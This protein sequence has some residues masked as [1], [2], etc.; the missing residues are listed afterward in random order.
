[1]NATIS[2]HLACAKRHKTP[3]VHSVRTENRALKKAA[4]YKSDT[5]SYTKPRVFKRGGKRDRQGKVTHNLSEKQVKDIYTAINKSVAIGLPLNRMINVHWERAGISTRGAI[6]ATGQLLKY[7][8]DW[9][10]RRGLPFAYVWIRE[11]DDGDGSKGD[12]V[13]I[14]AHIPR[15]MT[16]R[17]G[18]SWI[19][20][21]TSGRYRQGVLLTCRI[22]GIA[23]AAGA[24]PEHYAV[25]L[26]VVAGYVLK[27][28]CEADMRA[29][30]LWRWNGGGR[31]TG[32]RC[33][34]SKNLSRAVQTGQVAY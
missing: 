18:R 12:H 1:M 24:T 27:G 31:V 23:N 15:G 30:G 16:L 26:A 20:R 19:N 32:Q 22:G 29:Q 13:H 28:G 6:A 10:T 33:G 4:A 7:A 25:N 8:R 9:L 3:Y 2:A 14:L 21:I 11:N 34:L 5:P 17:L